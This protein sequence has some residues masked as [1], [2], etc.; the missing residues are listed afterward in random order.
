MNC[1]GKIICSGCIHAFQSRAT[2]KEHDVCPFC[3]TPPVSTNGEMIKRYEKRIKLNDANAFTN[4]G[5]F[6]DQGQ[7]GLPQNFAKAFE[8]FHRAGELGSADAYY[9]I[10]NVFKFGEGGVE[11]DEKKAI[12]YWELAAMMG[13]VD[14]RHNLGVME[15]MADNYNRALKHFM[16]AARYGHGNSLTGIKLIYKN[17]DATKDEYTKALR[18]YQAYLDEIKSDQRD[19]AAA[20]DD[21]RYYESALL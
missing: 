18:S 20:S 6:Y 16:I 2:K 11:V 1:C 13:C 3:R 14:A 5:C 15:G 7:K 19:Q 9:D 21:G 17:G 8:L 10:G 12:H 4:M